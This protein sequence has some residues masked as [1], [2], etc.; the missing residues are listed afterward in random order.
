MHWN[1]K[2]FL[3]L[4]IIIVTLRN[5]YLAGSEK[6]F[7]KMIERIITHFE[8]N[9]FDV[10]TR[11]AEKFGIR[12]CQFRL[13]FV[14]LSFPTFGLNLVLY[15]ILALVIRIKDNIFIKRGSVFDL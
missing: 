11:S 12:V 2:H 4:E 15:L 13:F 10:C 9:G 14:Y 3:K 8:H 7:L 5:A 1:H 6:I